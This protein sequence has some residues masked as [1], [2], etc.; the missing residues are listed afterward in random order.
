MA[1]Y[2]TKTRAISSIF[3]PTN[4][5]G[6]ISPGQRWPGS[7]VKSGW[8]NWSGKRTAVARENLKKQDKETRE[9]TVGG[10]LT[11]TPI[12]YGRTCVGPAIAYAGVSGRYLHLVNV[13]GEG[14]IGGFDFI[15]NEGKNIVTRK[16]SDS[17][18]Y[19]GE[20]GTGITI[21]LF[22]GTATQVCPPA[23][24]AAFPSYTDDLPG[25]CYAHMMISRDSTL[26][27][28]FP[29]L[30]AVLR[31]LKVYDPRSGLTAYSNNP[32]LCLADALSNTVHGLGKTLD[33][34]SAA[35]AADDCDELVNGKPRRTIG[36]ALQ[37]MSPALDWVETLRAHAAVFLYEDGG[38]VH[39]I[40]DRPGTVVHTFDDDNILAGSLS[41]EYH[42]EN[43]LP[44]IVE[45][46]WTDPGNDDIT[47]RDDLHREVLPGA[48]P[49][50]IG[51]FHLPG[52][53]DPS[54]A[55]REAVERLNRSQYAN[56]VLAL[57]THDYG[58]QVT[59]GDLIEVTSDIGLAADQYRVTGAEALSSGEWKIT[60]EACDQ[61]IYSNQVK[62]RSDW[63]SVSLDDPN[64]PP[65]PTGLSAVELPFILGSGQ[66]ATRIRAVWDDMS[67]NYSHVRQYRVVVTGEGPF[68]DGTTLNNSFVSGTLQDGKTYT[69]SVSTISTTGAESEA[70]I[71]SI[72]ANGKAFIPGDVPRI[73]QLIEIGGS[74]LIAWDPAV[75]LDLVGYCIAAGSKTDTFDTA[76]RVVAGSR[77]PLKARQAAWPATRFEDRNVPAGDYRYFVKGVD[78]LAQFSANAAYADVTVT[79]DSAFRFVNEHTW[80]G[81]DFSPIKMAAYVV[82]GLGWCLLPDDGEDWH[83]GY[84]SEDSAWDADGL[85][86]VPLCLPRTDYGS[87]VYAISDVWNLGSLVSGQWI[88]G[89]VA[90]EDIETGDTAGVIFKLLLSDDGESY[91]EYEGR[92]IQG[93]GQYVKAKV[94]D[95]SD[96][97]NAASLVR[98]LPMTLTVFAQQREE[99]GEASVP[100]SPSQPYHVTLTKNYGSYTVGYPQVN[101]IGSSN[102]TARPDNVTNTGFDIWLFDKND[103][104]VAGTVGWVFKG[105]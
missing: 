41:I 75:D 10:Y 100:A 76:P 5:P 19:A 25:I 4:Y 24:T 93:T 11:P 22:R 98:L 49:D 104:Q 35:A 42:Q 3:L 36:L 83:E 47:W 65:V 50:R 82:E 32:A 37:E 57:T 88:M 6:A 45:V 18:W 87:G 86:N 26:V 46:T 69:V 53:T 14:E 95:D 74:V 102:Y 2:Y 51:R 105:V 43:Q 1:D 31:G 84:T 12:I 72:T 64:A 23:L 39:F 54:E 60:A 71:H 44:T 85:G 17:L 58:L 79:V 15:L 80:I 33:W 20:G 8:A 97:A 55:K 34:D 103:N 29:R 94:I 13:F 27:S 70:A 90:V 16:I 73:T 92:S 28:G 68:Y 66:W 91:T 99:S 59:P 30:T 21:N 7:V 40:S 81:S 77:D 61:R 101:Y 38:V 96:G 78:S 63:S 9:L 56:R 67:E 89:G 62:A 48:L 52:I